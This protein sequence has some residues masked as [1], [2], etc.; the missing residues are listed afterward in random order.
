M[1]RTF[2]N[3]FFLFLISAISLQ[4]CQGQSKANTGESNTT[5]I[6]EVLS[7]SEFQQKLGAMESAQLLDVRTPQEFMQGH[8]NG[9]V[10]INLFEQN[11]VEQVKKEFKTDEPVLLYC[12]S[13]K[14][15]ARA[16]A[17]LRKAGFQEIYDLQG[18]FL[19]WS[20]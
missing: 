18:G 15:S 5:S 6:S 17:Q 4:S 14:R 19:A 9:A 8:I 10:N 16:A 2:R 12:R 13:G 11:F 7:V 20:R 1:N 3:Y